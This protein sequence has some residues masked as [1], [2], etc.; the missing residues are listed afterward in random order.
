[1]SPGVTLG[2]SSTPHPTG[3]QTP[4]STLPE[5]SRFDQTMISNEAD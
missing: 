3:P 2:H 4:P 5:V 1:L